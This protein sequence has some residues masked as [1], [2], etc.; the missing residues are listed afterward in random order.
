[1][2]TDI[3][4]AAYSELGKQGIRTDTPV[5]LLDRRKIEAWLALGA[6]LEAMGTGIEGDQP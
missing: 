2:R 1:M 4:L 3:I 5:C 6:M